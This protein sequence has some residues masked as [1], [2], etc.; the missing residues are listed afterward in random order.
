VKKSELKQLI[1]EV[2]EEARK[3][4]LIET[5]PGNNLPGMVY[6]SPAGKQWKDIGLDMGTWMEKIRKG[7]GGGIYMKIVPSSLSGDK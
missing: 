6:I 1:R 2:F 4:S 3:E 5:T 7:S